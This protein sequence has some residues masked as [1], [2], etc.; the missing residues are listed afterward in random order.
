[1]E[2]E[3]VVVVVVKV[4]IPASNVVC[5]FLSPGFAFEANHPIHIHGLSFRVVAMD[6]VGQNVTL[7]QVMKLDAEGKIKRK[8]EKPVAKDTVTIP[9]GG[10]TV[11]RF[12]ASNPGILNCL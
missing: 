9:D 10:Y 11:I 8:L 6:R 1:M 7:Q 3:A 5:F 2:R 12:V 4:P